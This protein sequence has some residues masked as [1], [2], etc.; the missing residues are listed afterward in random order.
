MTAAH[1]ELLEKVIE[2]L[3]SMKRGGEKDLQRNPHSEDLLPFFQEYAWRGIEVRDKES[4]L[5]APSLKEAKERI[6]AAIDRA[7]QE[8]C[9]RR[10]VVEGKTKPE[11][12]WFTAVREACQATDFNIAITPFGTYDCR[13]FLSPKR[14]QL[15]ALL[16]VQAE[17]LVQEFLDGLKSRGEPATPP[18]AA[19]YMPAQK[20]SRGGESSKESQG[21]NLPKESSGPVVA[22]MMRFPKRA[23][24]LQERLTERNWTITHFEKTGEGP[25]RKTVSRILNGEP[26]SK[27][28]LRKLAHSLC[29]YKGFRV[30]LQDIPRD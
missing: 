27:G 30:L 7:L 17:T 10:E 18:D 3:R 14:Q 2:F 29:G 23:E 4:I 1:R 13:A 28:S 15:A 19:E 21:E 24:W 26:V 6:A 20:D 8:V 5:A 22:A 16:R 11:G 25:S 12:I 9:K